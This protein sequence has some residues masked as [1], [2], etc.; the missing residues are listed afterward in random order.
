VKD[1]SPNTE[2]TALL[3]RGTRF[4]G[5]LHFDGPVRID[6][7]FRG[8]IQSDGLL[9]VGDGADV[10]GSIEVGSLIVKGGSLNARVRARESIEL[11]VP[12]QVSGHLHSPEIFI[13]KGVQFTGQMDMSALDAIDEAKKG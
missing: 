13:E 1:L 2:I 4:E 5:N 12:A 6:G 8:D 9:I 7:A 3:G 11:Y 10:E